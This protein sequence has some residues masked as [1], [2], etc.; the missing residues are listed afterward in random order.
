MQAARSL[1]QPTNSPSGGRNH[2]RLC[3]L[4][5]FGGEMATMFALLSLVA[6]CFVFGNLLGYDTRN[7]PVS[8]ATVIASRFSSQTQT[9]ALSTWTK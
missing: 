4:S 9:R 7:Q 5:H 2:I 6:I 8:P 1:V 3:L